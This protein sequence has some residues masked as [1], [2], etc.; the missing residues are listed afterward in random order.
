MTPP[1]LTF[2][3][4]TSW[5]LSCILAN[6]QTSLHTTAADNK[7]RLVA[8]VTFFWAKMTYYERDA[9][10]SV[11][12]FTHNSKWGQA[13]KMNLRSVHLAVRGKRPVKLY[14]NHRPPALQHVTLCV[15]VFMHTCQPAYFPR[16]VE[17]TN[18]NGL[19]LS[20]GL[21]DTT[22]LMW[23]RLTTVTGF[24]CCPS[25]LKIVTRQKSL[26]A[27]KRLQI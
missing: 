10:V 14:K 6:W 24:S 23:A 12:C 7:T 2:V 19:M 9:A 16:R 22:F 4:V 25:M 1:R 8:I 3:T 15:H 13:L 18:H 21:F 27:V 5:G 11:I 26:P 20:N 17:N